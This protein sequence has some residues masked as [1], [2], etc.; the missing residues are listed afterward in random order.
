VGSTP[1]WATEVVEEMP[2]RCQPGVAAWFSAKRSWVQI[3]P[4]VLCPIPKWSRGQAVTLEIRRFES[5]RTPSCWGKSE[6]RNPKSETNPKS[7]MQM[8]KTAKGEFRTLEFGILNL[9]RISSFGFR[10]L[11]FFGKT[12]KD[13]GFRIWTA[14]G[15]TDGSDLCLASTV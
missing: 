2:W 14:M 12:R 9:F 10:I 1:T 8:L 3:P 7:Q 15:V 6:I 5:A 11:S 4:R 13:I